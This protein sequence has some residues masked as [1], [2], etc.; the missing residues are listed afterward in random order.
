MNVRRPDGSKPTLRETILDWRGPGTIV[1]S[2]KT[3]ADYMIAEVD[4]GA[5]DGFVVLGEVLP[6]S[7]NDYTEMVVPELQRR[8]RFRTEHQ[9]GETFRDRL[10]LNRPANRFVAGDE[11]VLPSR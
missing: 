5:C 8:G 9:E 2:P 7:I 11:Q 1:G 4:R 6:E 10:G 3:V